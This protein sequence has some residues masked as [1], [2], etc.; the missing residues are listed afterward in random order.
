MRDDPP[1]D[2]SRGRRPSRR[3]TVAALLATYMQAVNIS[4]PNAALPHIQGTLSM[5]NDEV[6][7]V[8]SSYIA[9]SAVVMPMTHWLA[10]RYGRK[11]IYQFSILPLRAR[12]SARHAGDH[13]PC[14]SCSLGSLQGAAS[15]PLA[16]LSLAVLL[17]VRRR[18]GTPGSAWRGHCASCSASAPDPASAAGSANITAGARSSISVCR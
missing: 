2:R 18:R 4:L 15:G 14:S 9:A 5:A 8:F 10:G 12:A 11:A 1:I 13:V 7:W 6:G 17:E 16:P 3:L